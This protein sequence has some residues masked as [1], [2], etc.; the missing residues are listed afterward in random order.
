MAD[1]ADT[2]LF[3]LKSL[4]ELAHIIGDYYTGSEITRFFERA[5]FPEIS[6]DGTTKWWFIYI[7]LQE[8]QGVGGPQL[9][10]RILER[11]YNPKEHTSAS[12]LKSIS[13]ILTDYNLTTTKD[14]K[15]VA[16]LHPPEIVKNLELIAQR[17]FR[18]AQQ[19]SDR[20][21]HRPT[22]E[23]NNEYDVQDLFHAL[24]LIFFED[25]RSEETT[26]SYGGS[27]SRIDFLLKQEETIVEIKMT[28]ENLSSKEL[29]NQLLI[30]IA[31]YPSHPDCKIFVAFVY[32]PEHR[33][34]NPVGLESDLSKPVNG[35]EVRV[36]IYPK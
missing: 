29:K 6:H 20:H 16:K 9:V 5:G 36:M 19:L 21:E 11:L 32:D 24:L 18:I 1:L 33:I 27:R 34:K 10:I 28:R 12:I 23:I 4:E 22:L 14:G 2:E 13:Q 35:M 7:T 25:V 26:P 8:L 3:D 15:I 31:S 17:F 30:D